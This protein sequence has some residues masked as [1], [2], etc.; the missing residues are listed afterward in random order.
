M[1]FRYAIGGIAIAAV[2]VLPSGA[3]AKQ[4]GGGGSVDQ[5]AAAQCAQERQDI[6]RNAFHKKYGDRQSMRSCVRRTRG[7]VRAAVNQANQDCQAE[8]TQDGV[9]SF[10]EDYGTDPTRSDAFEECVAEGADDLLN[11]GD[12]SDSEDD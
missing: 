5:L 2:L 11:P 8:L 9:A 12:D 6:G 3:A 10:I 4:G 1:N 7:R